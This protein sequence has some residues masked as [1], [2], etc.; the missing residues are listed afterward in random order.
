MK[1]KKKMSSFVPIIV[2]IVVLV[3][4]VGMFFGLN[5]IPYKGEKPD[6]ILR[7]DN[8][9][10]AEEQYAATL[11]MGDKDE[12]VI[13]NLADIQI[14]DLKLSKHKPTFKMLDKLIKA[15]KPD[16]ITLTGDQVSGVF[17][18]YTLKKI[19]KFLDGYGIPWAP[20]LGNH[21]GQW[22]VTR[23]GNGDI[24]LSG[25]YKNVVFRKNDPSLGVGNY[26]IN[27]AKNNKS[28]HTVFMIDSHDSRTYDSGKDYDYIWQSQ[29]D[30]YDW[31]VKGIAETNGG[32]VVPSS[33]FFHIPLVEYIDAYK[34]YEEGIY[35]GGNVNNEEVCCAEHNN[36]DNPYNSGF[37]SKLQEL[38]STKLVMV[39]HDHTNCS[40]VN[41][42]G[43]TLA[44]GLKSGYG[45]YYNDNVI[46]GTVVKVNKN[47][48]TS[49]DY[50]HYVNGEIQLDNNS[51]NYKSK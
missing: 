31:A 14:E 37:F 26:I 6:E 21:D 40:W 35:E 39:G 48:S 2:I 41:Y 12:F 44:Y 29:I 11:D 51:E 8:A 15:T 13:L 47:G 38:D 45:S 28:V 25:K 16:L 22:N 33:C 18:R 3:V 27:I 42:K 7:I 5:F 23:N 30:W 36:K 17:V 10:N 9:F 4:G 24:Y 49:L 34:G 20:V 46:G 43:I 50:Y 1:L 19:C 32:K